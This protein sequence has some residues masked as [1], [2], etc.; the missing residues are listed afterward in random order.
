MAGW[1]ADT[2]ERILALD[3]VVVIDHVDEYGAPWFNY[4]LVG[5][6]GRPEHHSL[7]ICENESWELV[8]A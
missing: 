2:I 4:E 7:T 8:G 5:P 1:T 3:P 6:D